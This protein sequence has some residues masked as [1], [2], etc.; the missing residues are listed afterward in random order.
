MDLLPT[1][2]CDMFSLFLSKCYCT[3]PDSY[4][5]RL[6]VLVLSIVHEK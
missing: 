4:W 6:S 1:I 3:V 2:L 5:H